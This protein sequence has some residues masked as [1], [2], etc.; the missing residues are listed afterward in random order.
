[1]R[2]TCVIIE[3]IV[4]IVIE[5]M[6][7]MEDEEVLLGAVESGYRPRFSVGNTNHGVEGSS[8]PVLK[9]FQGSF[10][11]HAFLLLPHQLFKGSHNEWRSSG[12]GGV[13]ISLCFF[14][15]SPLSSALEA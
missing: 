15:G 2:D 5:E 8:F 3:H 11:P 1:M 10:D 4:I 9:S 12:G 7:G 14:K 13:L 6:E